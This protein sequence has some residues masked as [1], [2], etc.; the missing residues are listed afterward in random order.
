MTCI[1]LL[2][3]V[4][5]AG[6]NNDLNVTAPWKDIPIIY[7][8]LSPSDT[9]HYVRIEKAFLDPEV[10]ALEIARIPDSL[11]YKDLDVSIFD[12]SSGTRFQLEEIDGI[13]DGYVRDE[14]IF[15]EVPNILYKVDAKDLNLTAAN[16][17]RLEVNR[18]ERLPLVTAEIEIVSRPVIVR[19]LPERELRFPYE[20]LFKVIWRKAD[21]AFF[22]DVSL[23]IHYN[24]WTMGD[25]G[26][27]EAYSIQWK[28]ARSVSGDRVEIFGIG[29]YEFLRAELEADPTLLRS[30]SNID[31]IVRSGGRELF[32]F[33][34]V[35]LANSGITS[36][37]GDIPQY[38]NLS[39]GFGILTS[40]NSSQNSELVLHAVS[41]DSLRNGYLTEDLNF[42]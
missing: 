4:V 1:L 9:A 10:S 34:K 23:V 17:Y 25:P 31:V 29:F 38:T 19:P 30:L 16:S 35:L 11:Y 33:R 36:I 5:F 14:G 2:S 32:E 21:N 18:S 13:E 12:I 27:I 24:E 8:I 41:L 6:C 3:G 37:G 22:Y 28:L 7:G 15:A 42:Q 26:S 39:E 40:S 20:S